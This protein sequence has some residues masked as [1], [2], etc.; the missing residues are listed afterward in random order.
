MSDYDEDDE[1]NVEG[2]VCMLASQFPFEDASACREICEQLPGII[3]VML[4]SRV[5]RRDN[6]K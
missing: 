2:I 6:P 3:A 1:V 5:R 4:A